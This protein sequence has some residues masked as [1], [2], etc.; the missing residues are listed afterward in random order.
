[1]AN[2]IIHHNGAYNIFGT[3]ADG[4]HYENALTLDQLR[5]V[6]KREH[7]KA[8]LDY[9]PQRLGRA[10]LT[11]CSG[12]GHS[13]DDCIA[14]N[15]QGPNESHMPRD[16]FIARFLTLPATEFGAEREANK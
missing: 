8:G 2:F 10:H 4:A 13:L 3:V 5:A 1:V 11:G 6:I 12:L 7:G 16:E 9:L 14:Q 15:R